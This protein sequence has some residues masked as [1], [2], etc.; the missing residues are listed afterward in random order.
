M[1]H[2]A[3]HSSL[4]AFTPTKHMAK[5]TRTPGNRRIAESEFTLKRQCPPGQVQLSAPFQGQ[6]V[7]DGH[8]SS[9]VRNA[10][11]HRARNQQGEGEGQPSAKL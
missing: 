2:R 8:S 9:Q 3:T 5:T 11:Q 7:R 1:Q 6:T 10:N 4:G